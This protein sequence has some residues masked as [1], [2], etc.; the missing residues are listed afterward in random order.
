MGP[1]RIRGYEGG[2]SLNDQIFINNWNEAGDPK[3]TDANPSETTNPFDQKYPNFNLQQDSPC[4]DTGAF[5]TKTTNSGTNS[6][7][8]KVQ[9]AH[10]FMDGWDFPSYMGVQGDLIQL[11]GQTQRARITDINYNTN[12][13]TVDTPLTWSFGMG[14][15]LTYDG[16]KPDMGAFE[17]GESEP[18]PSICGDETCNGPET[19]S[20]CPE[21][22]SACPEPSHTYRATRTYS[23]PGIDGNASEF[24]KAHSI[25]LS[26]SRGT[27]G[28]YM[29]LWDE[30]ALYIA[31]EVSDSEMNAENNQEDGQLWND[32]SIELF[33]DTLKNRGTAQGQDDYK[34]FVN[35]NN[36]HHDNKGFDSTWDAAYHSYVDPDGTVNVNT[37]TDNGYVIEIAI[38]WAVWGVAAPSSGNTWGFDLS[39]NDRDASGTKLKTKWANTDGGDSNNPSGWGDLIFTHRADTSPDYGCI[40]QNELI[41]FISLWKTPS[42][43]VSMPELIGAIGLWKQG[44]GC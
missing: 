27:A 33:F 17:F 44:T 31:A 15:S 39:M 13:I 18:Q 36:Y 14:L 5:L 10:Y 7:S 35:A 32:D 26:N 25:Q 29:L 3:F 37:D 42:T 4:R 12:T 16:S 2:G 30:T 20:S 38:P 8:I 43:D 21:D 11:E 24:S 1:L 22:C 19:C 41:D 9:D 23:I 6:Q 28:T 34:F 40:K